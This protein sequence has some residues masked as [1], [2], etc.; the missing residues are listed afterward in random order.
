M[1]EFDAEWDYIYADFDPAELDHGDQ[2]D[3]WTQERDTVERN[4]EYTPDH[5]PIIRKQPRYRFGHPQGVRVGDV[6]TYRWV[7]SFMLSVL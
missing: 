1:S 4:R 2:D 7:L 3:E 6:F 5:E